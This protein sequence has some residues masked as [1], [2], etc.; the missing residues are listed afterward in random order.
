MD[1]GK[2]YAELVASRKPRGTKK[3]SHYEIHHIIPRC[4]GGADVK[5][6]YVKLTFR[7]HYIAHWLLT[8]I[9]P[10]SIG[11]HYGFLCMLRDPHG[12]RLLT[13]RMVEN[14]KKQFS[15]FKRWHINVSNPGKTSQS[16]EAASQRM[17]S[18][19][20]PMKGHP[21]KNHTAAPHTV[22][23]TNGTTKTYTYGKLGYEELKISRSTWI[24]AVRTGKAIPK[25]K[26]SKIIKDKKI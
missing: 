23:F 6:N 17:N 9:Y 13:S 1:Y 24:V 22:F 5:E 14:I 11:I 15:D 18:E 7:E 3:E 25:Y 8:K 10:N 26:I 21:E 16:R 12:K 2:V 20:N 4:L 19:R